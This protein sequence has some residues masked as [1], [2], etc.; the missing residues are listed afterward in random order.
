WS[1]LYFIV[2]LQSL[3]LVECTGPEAYV[4]CLLEKDDVSWFPQSMAKCL[5]K[6]NEH[7][8]E[9]DL[10]EIKGQLKALASQVV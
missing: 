2:H 6:T 4:K 7:S 5:A 9:H 10:V 1:Y 3:S 8:T